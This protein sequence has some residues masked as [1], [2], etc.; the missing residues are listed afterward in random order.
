MRAFLIPRTVEGARIGAMY[1]IPLSMLSEQDL[2]DEKKRLTLQ[3]KTSFGPPQPP[4]PVYVVIAEHLYVPRFYGLQRFG[5]PEVDE[6]T[7]GMDACISFTGEL[8]DVQQRAHV[9][10]F[11]TYFVGEGGGAIVVLPCGM[12]KTVLA[13]AAAARLGRK[14][15]VLVHTTVLK[16]Q[17]K[18]SFERFCPDVKV[19]MVQGAVFAVEGMDVVIM[20]VQTVAKRQFAYDITDQFGFLICD[21]AHHMAAPVMNQAMRCFRC[22]YILA[23]TATKERVDG[24]THLL[25][26]SLGPEAFRAERT[27]EAARVTVVHYRGAAVE[28]TTKDGRPLVAIMLNLLAVNEGRNRFI[29]SRIVHLRERGRTIIVLSHRVAQLKALRRLLAHSIAE[30]EVGVLEAALNEARRSVQLARP[31]LLCSYNMADEGL[32]KRELD[33]CIMATP[34]T[35]VKQCIGRIQRPCETKQSPLVI[36]VADDGTYYG[37]L[38]HARQNFYRSERYEVQRVQA[39]DAYTDHWFE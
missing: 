10:L 17:W 12:G 30:D 29:A 6:R 27:S 19:G 39:S 3:P 13:V 35:R 21:E 23:L 4:F 8:T 9:A 36:D 37:R 31:V 1:S 38:A 18:N 25:H 32:D 22:K 14:V 5:Q 34:K 16:T 11:G 24:L 28:K 7:G 2:Q 33:T 15:A 26:W 20:M